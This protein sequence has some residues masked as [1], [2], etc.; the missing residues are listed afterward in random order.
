MTTSY[1]I[2]VSGMTCNHCRMRVKRALAALPEVSEVE[3]DL[4]SGRA[5]LV[6]AR[7]LDVA[8]LLRTVEAEGYAGAMAASAG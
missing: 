7:E 1:E 6:A 8:L 4:A 3:V 5:K 2:E